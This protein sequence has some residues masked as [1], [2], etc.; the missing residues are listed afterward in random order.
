[1]LLV[2]EETSAEQIAPERKIINEGLIL[3]SIVSLYV[4]AFVRSRRGLWAEKKTKY[5]SLAV[6]ILVVDYV[7]DTRVDFMLQ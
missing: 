1:M 2:L 6:S 5:I 3:A 7:I 4:Y